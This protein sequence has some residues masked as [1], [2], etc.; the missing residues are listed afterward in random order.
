M[1]LG[2]DKNKTR[3]S[4]SQIFF[5]SVQPVGYLF[6]KNYFCT[7]DTHIYRD[8]HVSSHK[9]VQLPQGVRAKSPL[10]APNNEYHALHFRLVQTLSLRKFSVE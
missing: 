5:E 7:S 4:Y 2:I 1:N 10:L 6:L 3:A 9:T 8:M